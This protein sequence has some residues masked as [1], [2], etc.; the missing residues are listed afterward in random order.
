MSITNCIDK[1]NK[2]VH[3]MGEVNEEMYLLVQRA[4]GI[5]YADP[6]QFVFTINTEGGIVTDALAIYD[7]IKSCCPEAKIV[8]Y[9]SC[10]S[11]G[12]IIL[13]A[14]KERIAA[15][16][17]ELMIHYG[18]DENESGQDK[19]FNT[20]LTKK[21]ADILLEKTKVSKATMGKWMN[22]TRYFSTDEALKFGLIDRVLS[23]D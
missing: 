7:L 5:L 16:N 3:L 8:I 12:M 1:A 4:I 19:K 14:A 9:G 13:Q 21:M 20:R 15:P 2:T 11:A 17:A 10:M 23:D 6:R 18:H 22:G